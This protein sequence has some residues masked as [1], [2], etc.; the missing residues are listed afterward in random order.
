MQALATGGPFWARASNR[1][2]EVSDSREAPGGRKAVFIYRTL[3]RRLRGFAR[4]PP[5]LLAYL[6]LTPTLNSLLILK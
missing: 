3:G 1:P 5:R 2:K 6:V 4:H